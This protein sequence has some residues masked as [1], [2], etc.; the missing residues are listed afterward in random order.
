MIPRYQRIAFWVLAGAILL[1]AA[2]TI[3]ARQRVHERI[4]QANDAM[5]YVAPVN[6]QTES[7]T[8]E[9]AND[10]DGS[11]LSALRDVA[12]PQEPSMRAKALLERLFAEY[13][14]PDSMHPL[15]AGPKVDDV[16]LLKA[17]TAPASSDL[18]SAG[19]IAV[20]NLRSSFADTHPSG[21]EVETLTIQSIIGTLHA[22]LPQITEVRFLV[23]GQQRETLAGHA[24]L[25][26]TYPAVDTSFQPTA[27]TEN[28][29][30]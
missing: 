26:R 15:R 1:M 4:A 3:H 13:S 28:P 22:N 18:D 9:L 12:L 17:P 29:P 27:P 23:D 7:V 11:I 20:V 5:P 14:Q 30:Q 10:A 8:L 6:A 21:I 24:D 25:L 16:F 19:M 2:F